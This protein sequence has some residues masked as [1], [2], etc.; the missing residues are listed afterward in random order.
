MRIA[1]FTTSNWRD[2]AEAKQKAPLLRQW[3]I[4]CSRLFKPDFSFIACGSYSS[5]EFNPIPDFA[6]VVN[7]G[8]KFTKPYDIWNWTYGSCALTAALWCAQFNS[9]GFDYLVCVDLDLAIGDI[10]FGKMLR[11]FDQRQ[12]ILCAPYWHGNPDMHQFSIWKKPAIVRYCHHRLRGNLYDTPPEKQILG[13]EEW[14]KIF[15]GYWWNITPQ[16]ASIRQ[17]ASIPKPVPDEIAAQWPMV[18]SASDAI[19]K[20]FLETKTPSAKPIK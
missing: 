4:T 15:K 2:E 6:L 18:A 3:E 7:S 20:L 16:F 14:G 19:K 8:A 5:P 9:D 10:D 11:D 13:E 17:D 12:E 1:L